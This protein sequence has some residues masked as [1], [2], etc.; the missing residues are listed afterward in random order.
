MTRTGILAIGFL[1]AAGTLHVAAQE[2]SAAALQQS[3]TSGAR[4]AVTRLLPGTRRDVLGTIQGNA[5][6]STNGQL[7]S[8]SV[9]LRD[10]RLG[11][12]VDAQLT[13]RAGSFAF[14]AIDPGSYIVEIIGTDRT[15]LAA[16]QL[17]NVNAGQAVSAVVKLP[18]R[19]PQF[20]GLLGNTTPSA[21]AV[22]AAAAGSS[23]LA[24][25]T[26][27]EAESPVR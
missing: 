21:A 9:R 11:R 22:T 17:V 15:V 18:F 20:A 4:S 16:S 7:P 8:A 26:A 23:V 2:Q 6:S 24:A 25:T 1:V 12:I 27:G 10:A 13:D 3:L 19:I 14:K 5:L